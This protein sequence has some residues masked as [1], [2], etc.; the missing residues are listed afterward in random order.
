MALIT[1]S[2]PNRQGACRPDEAARVR[3][4]GAQVMTMAQLELGL[5]SLALSV[6]QQELGHACCTPFAP[7]PGHDNPWQQQRLNFWRLGRGWCPE[8]ASLQDV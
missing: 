6:L 2:G 8:A 7:Q 1:T 5:V 3:S 4:L